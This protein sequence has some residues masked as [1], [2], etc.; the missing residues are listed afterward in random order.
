[1]TVTMK[2]A[3]SALP[4]TLAHWERAGVRGAVMA[5]ATDFV[6]YWFSGVALRPWPLA[7]RPSCKLYRRA[8]CGWA[9]DRRRQGGR[10]RAYLDV[11]AA[12]PDGPYPTLAQQLSY[13]GSQCVP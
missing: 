4:V 2:F 12:C 9:R 1:M 3:R 8:G 11:F 13:R 10:R 6:P 7:R 5:A